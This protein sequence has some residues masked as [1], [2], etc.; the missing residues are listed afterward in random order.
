MTA[1]TRYSR[2]AKFDK[3]TAPDASPEETA[4]HYA[5]AP[6]DEEVRRME[7]IWGV[8]RLPGLVSPEMAARWG[9]AMA[10][11]NAAIEARDVA[12]V[13]ARVGVCLRGLAAMHAEAEAAGKPKSDPAIIELSDGDTFKFAILPDG[14]DWPALKAARPDLLF[15]TGQEVIAAM[16]AWHSAIPA[17]E[18]IR[19]SFPDAQISKIKTKTEELVDD[20]INW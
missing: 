5:L 4:C 9:T 15:F 17:L 12:D 7:R 2:P 8:D 6:F 19:K 16:K 10:Q 13:T 3:F 14:R 18:H 20:E 11:L 1:T